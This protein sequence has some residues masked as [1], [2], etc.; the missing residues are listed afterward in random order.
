MRWGR[1]AAVLVAAATLAVPLKSD[2]DSGR[3]PAPADPDVRKGTPDDPGFDCNEPDDEDGPPSCANVWDE[4]FNLF[5]FAP[6]STKATATY[7]DLARLGEPQISGVKADAGWKYGIGAPDAAV[8]VLDTGIRWDNGR[9]RSKV[10]INA[11][12]IP[13]PPPDGDGNGVVSVDDF[14]AL[15]L[16][17]TNGTGNVDGQDIIR[18]YSD[19]VD[20]DGNGY[21]DDIAGWDFFEDDNDPQDVSSY[22][23]ARNHGTGRAGEAVQETDDAEGDA[24]LCPECS[25]MPLK[26]WDSFVVIGDQYGMATAYAADNGAASV[27]AA[28]GV[29][30][31]TRTAKAATRYAFEKGVALMEVSSD[32]N[33]ANHNYPTNYHETIYIN[34]CVAD[35]HGLG[36]EIPGLSDF[37]TSL[38]LG[39]QVPVGTWFRNSN[40][41]QYG[42]HAH[43]C[44]VGT[45]GS[46]ATGQAGGAAALLAARGRETAVST[47]GALTANEI[48]QLFTMTA[49]DVLPENTLGTGT[50]DP[51][52]VGWDQHF[53]Y[54]RADLG[55]AMARIAPGSIPPEAWLDEPAFWALIDPVTDPSPAVRGHVAAD[56]S[57]GYEWHLEW[58]PGLEPTDADFEPIASGDGTDAFDGMLGSLPMDDIAD[59]LPGSRTGKPPDTPNE[60]TFTVRLVVVDDDGNR[61][62]D[63]KV[64]FAYHDPTAHPGWPRFADTGGEQS[65]VLYD[66]DG[67]GTL[68]VVDANSSGELTVTQADG[69]PLPSFNG[70]DPWL[71]S[72]TWNA[73]LDAPAFASGA[74]PA[75]TA[76]FRTPAIDDVDGDLSPDIV[77]AA[78]DGRVYVLDASGGV[79][80]GYPVGVD[81]ALS[82]PVLRNENNHVKRGILGSPT[83]ADLDGDGT[84]ELIVAALDGRVYVWDAASGTPR[85]G[86]PVWLKDPAAP[87]FYG[88]E[89]ISTPA[90][91]DLDGD[92]TFEIVIES[93]EVY[94]EG[95][96]VPDSPDDLEEAFQRFL[97]NGVNGVLGDA[98]GRIYALD[99]DGSFVAGWPRPLDGLLVDI[100]P[101]VAPAMTVAVAD[102][103]D[104]GNDEVIAGVVSG[105]QRVLDGDGT[106]L[107]HFREVG[108]V[109][110]VPPHPETVF[111]NL[112]EY[113]AIGDLDDDGDLEMAKGGGTLFLAANLVLVGQNLPFQHLVQAWDATPNAITGEGEFRPGYPR[114][115]DD[116]MLLMTPAIADVG[117][118]DGREIVVGSGLYLVHAFGPLGQEAEGFPKL[119]GGWISTVPAVGDVDGDG[120]LELV[121]TTREGWR[122]MWDLDSPAVPGTNEEWWTEAHDECHTNRHGT[123]CRPPSAVPDLVIAADGSR[124]SFSPT[125]DDWR[126]GSASAYEVRAAPTAITDFATWST[127]AVVDVD[128]A[129]GTLALPP[130]TRS[131]AV[132]ATDDA[133]NR[134]M[135][136]TATAGAA[137]AGP[138]PAT[139]GLDRREP[140]AR[141]GGEDV[142]WLAALLLVLSAVFRLWGRK[143]PTG[144]RGR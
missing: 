132:V 84:T 77:L 5:G 57:T 85:A 31:N 94:G 4:Q 55:A 28:L 21:V 121:A 80:P 82:A 93:S 130:G 54:G 40:L 142:A 66:M 6:E 38:G 3:F 133:G 139:G 16:P 59:S 30:S 71:L 68:E 29:L 2:A 67:N 44:F 78:T 97:E 74:V 15:A 95:L 18:A 103:D 109:N 42:G 12:E 24:A 112:A 99:D 73:H 36:T 87:E 45:T 98:T 113:P 102:L 88:G 125:G 17:D 13:V 25:L 50:P 92:G 122:F 115:N 8:A 116:F 126:S 23:S 46:E 1:A 138:A 101:L 32:L 33:T 75:P 63:R 70:G 65:L 76:G 20:D 123:D 135:L 79:K 119:V 49:E 86:F 52:Q 134:S 91:A 120:S 140:V 118:A 83:L 108:V 117:G 96:S 22:S 110:T 58:A 41:T 61:G 105:E 14:A 27:V 35:T 10:R 69:S 11:G 124:A 114:P 62:D 127:A 90:L 48:K 137:A 53:G 47:G 141:T 51:A 43:V 26:V 37:L 34:G 60:F 131:V 128:A 100:L 144:R 107:Y 129:P 104:D 7:L 89:L 9:L 136:A 64:Y 81:P 111:A 72:P 106:D 56:R 19:G 39:S 143:L